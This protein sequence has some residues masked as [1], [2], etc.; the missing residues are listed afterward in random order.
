MPYYPPHPEPEPNGPEK[1]RG[2]K[3]E[4]EPFRSHAL[5]TGAVCLLASLALYGGIR[6]ISYITDLAA[7]RKTKYEMMSV[8]HE[9]E[10][11]RDTAR[12]PAAAESSENRRMKLKLREITVPA[13]EVIVANG[14]DDESEQSDLL[15]AVEYENNYQVVPAVQKL[16]QKDPYVTGWLK[17][18]DL[19]EPVALKD[20]S[21]FLDHDAAGKKNYN[22]AIFLDEDTNLLTRP[23]T[24]FLY[25]HNMKSGNM[26][27][28]LRKYKA[29]SYCHANRFIHFDTIFE[30][31][32]YVIFAVS[33]ISLTP[34]TLN[35]V[36]L[37]GLQ[38]I[39]R[40]ERTQALNTI[41][42]CSDYTSTL[43]VAAE[44][45][46]LLLI[47]CVGNHD[48]RLIIAARRLRQGEQENSLNLVV[49]RRRPESGRN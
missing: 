35:Y 2:K 27:G 43:D 29:F 26:F 44:D 14:S 28:N 49:R 40:S 10:S 42:R 47:T 36:N 4:K 37:S 11:S 16:K 32:T 7:S 19:E 15:P 5:R 22:G 6:L 18:G 33:E 24:L 3:Q 25:G 48:E 30:E 39:S 9:T 12:E 13:S 46:I 23:Y 21:F 1:K 17:M 45:Q 34:N 41:I 31:G 38:G 8:M 20:N